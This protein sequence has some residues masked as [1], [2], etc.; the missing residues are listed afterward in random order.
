M[1]MAHPLLS[2]EEKQTES[3]FNCDLGTQKGI[4]LL[5]GLETSGD[6]VYISLGTN[7]T[8]IRIPAEGPEGRW[9]KVKVNALRVLQISHGRR[10]DKESACSLHTPAGTGTPF[11]RLSAA[12]ASSRP[13]GRSALLLPLG[14]TQMDCES[15]SENPCQALWDLGQS[16]VFL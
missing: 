11:L 3:G 8:G 6:N 4:C 5:L 7:C 14:Q 2:R 1:L 15:F 12:L 9:G 10:K 13:L 16:C